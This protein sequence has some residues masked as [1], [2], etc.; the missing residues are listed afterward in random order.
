MTA[1][2]PSEIDRASLGSIIDPCG[3]TI[4]RSDSPTSIFTKRDFMRDLVRD[5]LPGTQIHQPQVPLHLLVVHDLQKRR[6]LQL[7][8]YA[9]A[10]RAVEDRVTSAVGEV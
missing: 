5:S 9:L 4:A 7:D 8:R 2:V 3:S 6:L 10:Q 1:G